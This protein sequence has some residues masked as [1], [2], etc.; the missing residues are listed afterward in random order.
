MI[1]ER[2]RERERIGDENEG[3]RYRMKDKQG[4]YTYGIMSVTLEISLG[5]S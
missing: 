4:E 2:K 1:S 5:D 3:C